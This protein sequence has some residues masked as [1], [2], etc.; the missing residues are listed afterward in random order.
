MHTDDYQRSARLDTYRV[1]ADS[2]DGRGENIYLVRFHY[3]PP[4]GKRSRRT[5]DILPQNR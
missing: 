3:I 2:G 5:P 4:R 1:I